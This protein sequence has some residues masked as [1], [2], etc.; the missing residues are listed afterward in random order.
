VA[1]PQH[2]LQSNGRDRDI[3]DG[4]G[5]PAAADL[6]LDANQTLSDGDQTLAD[7]D[8]TTSDS[9]QTAADGDEAAA[10]SDQAAADDDQAASD[11]D[12]AAGG[13]PE[14]HG[15]SRHV[16]EE[17]A[18]QRR[19]GN[20]TR[21]ESALT[22]DS[23]AEA[24]DLA[25]A[26]RDKAS[27]LLDHELDQRDA[28]W[29]SAHPAREETESAARARVNR[30]R[31][32]ADRVLAAEARARA[33][34]DRDQAA[35]DRAAAAEDRHRALEDR[36]ALLRELAASELDALTGARN[37]GPGL[38]DLDNE[39][40][41]ARRTTDGLL[42]VAYVDVVGLKKVNDEQGHS[43]GDN[44]LRDS[45]RVIRDHLR[46]YD[47]IVRIGGDEFVCV[48]SGAAVQVVRE[49]FDSVQAKL[50]GDRP[51]GAIKVGIAAL[52]SGESATELI[53]RADIE[54]QSG[55]R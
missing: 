3:A 48:I 25:A 55:R 16:R 28:A 52:G 15:T 54:M 13:S 27:A 20:R 45:V 39:I 51:G 49:R 12:F 50:A 18:K 17:S 2:R 14:V 29:A 44:L 4:A 8:Q 7:I 35:S 41:R 10:A 5:S 21:T 26:A 33:A 6:D 19:D 40:E 23:V 34:A 30:E 24:R 46:S 31:A 43:A 1:D 11:R 32:A 42:A 47:A 38:A 9:D 22:R 53:G 37:R 36:D